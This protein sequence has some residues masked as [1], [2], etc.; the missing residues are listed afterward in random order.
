MNRARL[1]A[2]VSLGACVPFAGCGKRPEAPAKTAG[3]TAAQVPPATEV[4]AATRVRTVE[5]GALAKADLRQPRSLRVD[6]SGNLYV[7]DY[8]GR[9]IVVLNAVGTLRNRW[10][11]GA[12]DVLGVDIGP[13]GLF[14]AL[15]S[16]T[17]KVTVYSVDG[18]ALR[19][20][21]LSARNAA[22]NPRGFAVA[23]DGT[24]YV[25]DTGG[26]RLLHIAADGKPIKVIGGADPLKFAEPSDVA[27]AT[28]GMVALA[29][30]ANKRVVLLTAQGDFVRAVGIP[31]KGGFDGI[32]L[33][34]AEDGSFLA[35]SVDT[36]FVIPKDGSAVA[37][38]GQGAG[39]PHE[40]EAQAAGVA[41]DA[42]E[43]VFYASDPAARTL[44][45]FKLK[46]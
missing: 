44:K 40:F 34:K 8:A 7:V 26:S 5:G 21:D 27:V 13:D 25:A 37:V 2:I 31:G 33:D 20:I 24:F 12:A 10:S 38:A 23:P 4:A 36:V 41:W 3:S 16:A 32:R 43:K 42:R 11:F 28:S 46:S 22:Y 9:Q 19:S 1:F 14:Y 30:G 18:K 29:D 39:N 45:T 6:P 15:D 35:A 17:M